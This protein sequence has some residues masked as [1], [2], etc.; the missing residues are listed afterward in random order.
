MNK[1]GSG[2]PIQGRRLDYDYNQGRYQNL[3]GWAQPLFG[4]YLHRA[5]LAI[6]EA[7]GSLFARNQ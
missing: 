6:L 3:Y 2:Q 1:H 4:Q 7:G 5:A